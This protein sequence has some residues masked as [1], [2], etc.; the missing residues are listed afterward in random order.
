LRILRY[1]L[2][3]RKAKKHKFNVIKN[4]QTTR[5]FGELYNPHSEFA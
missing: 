1:S 2:V 5:K 4:K 3:K